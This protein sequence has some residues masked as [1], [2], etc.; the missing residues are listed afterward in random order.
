[1]ARIWLF[2][3]IVRGLSEKAP[4][5]FLRIVSFRRGRVIVSGSCRHGI[6]STFGLLAVV[7][8]QAVVPNILGPGTLVCVPLSCV[9]LVSVALHK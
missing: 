4:F 3:A 2:K 1:M 7:A 8:L 6:S 5:H 9:N